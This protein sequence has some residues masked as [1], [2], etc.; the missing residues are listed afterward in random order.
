MNN[1][2]HAVNFIKRFYMGLNRLWSL[3][4]IPVN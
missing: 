2:I 4:I 3:F 1:Y